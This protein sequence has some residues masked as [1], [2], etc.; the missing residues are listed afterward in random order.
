MAKIRGVRYLSPEP[1]RRLGTMKSKPGA[2][3]RARTS[4]PGMDFRAGAYLV[5]WMF[6]L[7]RSLVFLHRCT[8]GPC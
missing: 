8:W 6:D 4:G 5:F 2:R 7:V 1:A 3:P